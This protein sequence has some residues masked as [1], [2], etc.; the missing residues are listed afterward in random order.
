MLSGSILEHLFCSGREK[1]V[2]CKRAHWALMAEL[3]CRIWWCNF[4]VLVAI[5]RS[6][7][8]PAVPKT[9]RVVNHSRDSNSIHY[10]RG[11][12][13][14]LVGRGWRLTNPQRQAKSS[15]EMCRVQKMR[16]QSL[17]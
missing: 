11:F 6:P 7:M 9:L 12:E 1:S 17:A 14:G 10:L 3:C 15:P 8:D 5:P 16:P 4:Q 2:V 13:K